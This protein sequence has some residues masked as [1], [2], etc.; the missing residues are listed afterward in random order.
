M[1]TPPNTQEPALA[2]CTKKPNPC[3]AMEAAW[4]RNKARRESPIM[5][6]DLVPIWSRGT[7]RQSDA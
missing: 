2:D 1:T 6:R 3:D 4:A 7:V 5:A